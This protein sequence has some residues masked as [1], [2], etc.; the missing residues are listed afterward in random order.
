MDLDTFTVRVRPERDAVYVTPAGELDI[1]TVDQLGEQ[2]LELGDAG[3]H[4]VVI[5]LRELTFMDLCAVRL[6]CEL[7]AARSGR[8]LA[9]RADPGLRGRAQGPRVH[10]DALALAVHDGH[11][12]AQA[13]AASAGVRIRGRPTYTRA[14]RGARRARRGTRRLMTAR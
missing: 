4:R 9:A 3:F 8:R 1:A 14:R 6:L 2:V 12:A 10:R 13:P 5:D 11:V 7:E